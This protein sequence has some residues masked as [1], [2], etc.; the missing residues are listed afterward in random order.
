MISITPA[1]AEQILNSAREG[2]MEGMPLRVAA[3]KQEDGS[4][5]YGMGFDDSKLDGDARIT[6]EGIELVVA[7]TSSGLLQ[8]TVIDYVEL[9][10]GKFEFIF[11]NPN[12]PNH[13]SPEENR[14]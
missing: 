5:H 11:M 12:D 2:N 4:I 7:P 14:E 10:P 8:G 6:S 9:D 3:Q 13:T 1:A